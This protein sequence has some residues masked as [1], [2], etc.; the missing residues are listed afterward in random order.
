MVTE[1]TN[2]VSIKYFMKTNHFLSKHFRI[3]S[4]FIN[5][6]L[7]WKVFTPLARLTYVVYLIHLIHLTVF[8]L[9]IRIPYYYTKYT[10]TEHYFGTILMTFVMAFVICLTVEMP[11]LNLERLLLPSRTSKYYIIP[12]FYFNPFELNY[13][14]YPHFTE[15][16]DAVVDIQQEL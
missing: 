8:H 14:V 11:F 5:R 16:P 2:F 7:S 10:H 4:G 15:K 13:F 3:S 9:S 12:R 1:V 6:F